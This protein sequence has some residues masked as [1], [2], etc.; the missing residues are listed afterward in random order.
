MSRSQRDKG[1]VGEREA[2]RVLN[3]LGI[4]AVR[5]GPLETGGIFKGD[6]Q[7][8]IGGVRRIGSVK[9]GG[10]VPKFIPDALLNNEHA[11]FCRRTDG[12]AI[13]WYVVQ[14]VEEWATEKAETQEDGDE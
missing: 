11:L 2:V 8:R 7:Y 12:D 4:P 13:Q 6:V 10:H 1:G 14:R 9:Y 3:K 5:I